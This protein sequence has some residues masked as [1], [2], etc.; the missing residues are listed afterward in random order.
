M[1]SIVW[2]DNTEY[3]KS[4]DATY[5]WVGQSDIDYTRARLPK[6]ANVTSAVASF[7]V[8]K[9]TGA[10]NTKWA[11]ADDNKSGSQTQLAGSNI[12]STS[13]STKQVSIAYAIKP[14]RV[15]TGNNV[16]DWFQPTNTYIRF[17]VSSGTLKT[18]MRNLKIQVDFDDVVFTPTV[19]TGGT[20]SGTA[21]YGISPNTTGGGS[22]T[23]DGTNTS[24]YFKYQA[25]ANTGSTFVEW[26]FSDGSSAGTSNPFSRNATSGY[27]SAENGSRCNFKAIF[28]LNNSTLSINPNGGS[29]SGSTST[30][31]FSGDYGSTKSIPIP[32][33]AGYRFTGWTRTNTYGSIT[34][35]T[36][37]ATYTYGSTDAVTDYL[38][39][40]WEIE[41]FSVSFNTHGGNS[42]SSVTKQ[43]GSTL[44]T[45]PTPTRAGYEFV[46]WFRTA[47]CF[48][49]GSFNGSDF[50]VVSR[51]YMFT[52]ALSIHIEAYMS[53]WSAISSKQQIMSCT[54]GGGWGIGYQANTTGHGTEIYIDG[55]GYK[56]I[57]FGIANLSSGWHTFDV[58]FANGT[59]SAKVD[60]VSKG[61]VATGG[62]AIK[63]HSS[64]A[65]FIG[66]EAG[67]SAS[68]PGGNYFTGSVSS[69]FIA[70]Q[71]AYLTAASS[72]DTV[73]SDVT[74]HAA[75]RPT[76]AQ[77][78][79]F[80]SAELKYNNAQVSSSNKVLAGE[81]YIISVGVS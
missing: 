36:A 79:T 74:L 54:E 22:A 20:G 57:D 45:L 50:V 76:V 13:Y 5:V 77:A 41:T 35:T 27:T 64:N 14:N 52:D 10:Y 78:P 61:S 23:F 3:S 19:S 53:D 39:A 44:G 21:T 65:I 68:T 16:E 7:Q 25:T 66:A 12:D 48:D 8:K 30:Q 31:T 70:N 38:V 47:P 81:G 62:T 2:S 63:Y 69:V 1:G 51:S 46:G 33:R 28:R 60:G 75:W 58:L 4:G 9:Q 32:T 40:N 80:T 29:W 34:S 49:S 71:T 55:V 42:I 18:Y 6:G 17:H 56:G 73:S 72:S 24:V 15:T 43:S 59:F 11:I 67:S 37:A 26:Q